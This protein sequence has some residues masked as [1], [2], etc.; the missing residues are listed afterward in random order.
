MFFAALHSFTFLVFVQSFLN[1][2]FAKEKKSIAV[3]A[4][5]LVVVSILSLTPYVFNGVMED[6]SGALS[7]KTS[8]GIVLFG[9]YIGACI[10]DGFYVIV[11]RLK[12]KRGVERSQMRSLFWG[13]AFT[14]MFVIVFSFSN[15]VLRGNVESVKYGHLYTLPFIVFTAYAMLRQHFLDLKA[16][17]AEVAVLLLS[18][19]LFVQLFSSESANRI[20]M[21]G[22]ILLGTIAIGIV[23]IRGVQKEIKQRE[24][25]QKLSEML[26]DAN[27]QLKQ[28]DQAR[29]DFITL[30]SHQLRTPPATIK[31]YLSAIN[32]G[33]Y[34][35]L[36]PDVKD[37][38]TKAEI[39]NNS[40]ISLI[41]DLLNA[42]R[43]ER[44]KL[45]FLFEPVHLDEL[46]KFTVEQLI[47]QA[48]IKGVGL[49][50]VPSK[51]PVPELLADKEKIRQVINNF[52]DNAIKYTPSGKITASVEVKDGYVSVLVKD[53]GKG[54]DKEVAS[55]LFEK[56]TRGK[57]A[58]THSTG[59]G[60]G[61]YVAKVVVDSHKGKIGVESEGV[62]K[63]STF[64][65]RLPIKNDLPKTKT[66]DLTVDKN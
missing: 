12:S 46:T 29:A 7:P 36:L 8:S 31:W 59:L 28:L 19:L 40:L 18:L 30:T 26:S 57:D 27:K 51:D 23:L 60:L 43:I 66:M 10:V 6:S 32:G 25:L 5:G 65:F 11:M 21:N 56:Y 41:D 33:D 42:S 62:G 34:G 37:A 22:V 64:F 45:E 38:V 55:T 16:V 48:T 44:G 39:A 3:F 2:N 1:S 20:V 49:E 63:G 14:F 54:V 24:Q 9:L 50:Y 4:I 52:V 53:T 15:F 13:L 35:E 17:I 61:L 58:V 47:P